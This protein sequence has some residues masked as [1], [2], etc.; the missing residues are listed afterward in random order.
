VNCHL[1]D[2][3]GANA[4]DPFDLIAELGGGQERTFI[5]QCNPEVP[6]VGEGLTFGRVDRALRRVLALFRHLPRI[7]L[8]HGVFSRVIPRHN[9]GRASWF[10]GRSLH[11]MAL[12][13]SKIAT[14]TDRVISSRADVRCAPNAKTTRPET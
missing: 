5:R 10:R 7:D 3:L 2:Q 12:A 13:V 9:A 14:A 6:N 1:A 8:R 4:V 11:G